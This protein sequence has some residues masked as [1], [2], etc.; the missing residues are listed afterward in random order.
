MDITLL[1]TASATAGAE[2]D[3]TFLL[4]RGRTDC[5]MVDVGGN[6]LGKL[7]K[8]GV[9]THDIQRVVLTHFH[10]DHMYGLPSLLWGMWLDG[11]TS[12]LHIHFASEEY[13]RM[14][15]WLKVL[16]MGEWPIAFEIVLEPFEW[17]KPAIIWETESL[18]VS[19]FPALHV[20]P[21]SGLKLETEGKTLIYSADT[22]PNPRI[23]AE[24]KID[25]LIHEATTA[26]EALPNHTSLRQ[27]AGYY[28]FNRIGSALLVHLS[29]GEAYERELDDLPAEA[30]NKIRLAQ[31]GMTITI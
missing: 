11:R 7:K 28:D 3:N 14:Q 5:F 17:T 10:I 30:R 16:R 8:L 9:A 15:S 19:A 18:R 1:G 13:D 23:A 6:P 25:L 21:T 12:P 24:E 22:M 27:A 4:V 26:T 20:G 29:D 2:R 31:D